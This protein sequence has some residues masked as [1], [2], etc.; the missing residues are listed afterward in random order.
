MLT[1]ERRNLD[2]IWY[3]NK[4]YLFKIKE[5]QDKAIIWIKL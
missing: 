4:N 3:K 1:E 5:K 2:I